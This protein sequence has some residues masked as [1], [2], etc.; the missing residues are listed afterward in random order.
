MEFAEA[1]MKTLCTTI[2]FPGRMIINPRANISDQPPN[3]CDPGHLIS[4]V[5]DKRLLMTAYVEM[6]PARTSRAIDSQS[7]TRAFIMSLAPLQE[8][9]LAYRKPRAIDNPLRETYIS[10]WLESLDDYLLKFRGVNKCPLA[11]VARS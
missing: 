6:H 10:N 1:D 3:I 4:M 2:R 7:M 5:A 11:C 8:Q 9:E